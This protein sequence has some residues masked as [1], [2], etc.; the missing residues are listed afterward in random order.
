MNDDATLEMLTNFVFN[1]L[2]DLNDDELKMSIGHTRDRIRK[3]KAILK[4]RTSEEPGSGE[5]GS[6]RNN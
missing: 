1:D 5:C 2:E 3:T 4:K 6:F